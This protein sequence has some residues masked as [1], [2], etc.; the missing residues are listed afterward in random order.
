[1]FLADKSKERKSLSHFGATRLSR[2]EALRVLTSNEPCC[3]YYTLMAF[4]PAD[5][6]TKHLGY[7]M[8]QDASNK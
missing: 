8:Y 1:M 3:N 5:S 4:D 6:G 7:I 2:S